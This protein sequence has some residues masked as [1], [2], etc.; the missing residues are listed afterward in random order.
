MHPTAQGYIDSAA[1]IL[2]GSLPVI[3]KALLLHKLSGSAEGYGTAMLSHSLTDYE[4]GVGV[5]CHTAAN[6]I[7]RMAEEILGYIRPEDED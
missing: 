4:P 2:D 3:S 1:I 5:D 6:R 7:Q